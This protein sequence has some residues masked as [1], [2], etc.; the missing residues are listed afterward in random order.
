MILADKYGHGKFFMEQV[1]GH[2]ILVIKAG[3][4]FFRKVDMNL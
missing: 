3:N 1:M 4:G 2:R